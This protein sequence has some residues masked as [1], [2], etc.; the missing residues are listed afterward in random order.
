MRSESAARQ[1]FAS[2]AWR[3]AGSAPGESMQITDNAR[4]L[5]TPPAPQVGEPASAERIAALDVA[6]GIAILLVI[7][8]HGL[9]AFFAVGPDAAF[10]DAAFA[11]WRVVYSFHMPLFFLISGMTARNL[12]QKS[13]RRILEQAL[14]L[15]AIAYVSHIA[16]V[17]LSAALGRVPAEAGAAVKTLVRPMLIG[18]DFSIVTTWFLVALAGVQILAAAIVKGPGA[19]RL[20]AIALLGFIV[21]ANPFIPNPF[22]IKS[23]A[24][25]VLF[26]LAGYALMR[27]GALPPAFVWAPCLA[28]VV[29]LAPLNGACLVEWSCAPLKGFVPEFLGGRFGVLMITGDIG[30]PPLFALTAL[31]GALAVLSLSRQL[32]TSRFGA[33]LA[34]NGRNA[35][36]LVLVN[37]FFLVFLQP[38]FAR[39]PLADTAIWRVGLGLSIVAAN[40]VLFVILAPFIRRLVGFSRLC[41]ARAVNAGA[42]S[43]RA[44]RAP[45]GVG[46]A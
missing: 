8:A 37:G 10:S 1:T 18:K 23:L 43:P 40:L 17:A 6:R 9:Q 21:V 30:F 36:D 13:W 25:G 44:R 19:A 7:Y 28:A 22:Q 24:P 29:A 26:Y 32:A 39:L 4:A 27:F 14:A 31:L 2:G 41:A 33:A 12:R 42:R 15:V 5:E 38:A 11:Q 20:A 34:W 16:G 35:L 46:E 3:S 45:S